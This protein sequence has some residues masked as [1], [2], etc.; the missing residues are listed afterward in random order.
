M[1]R[2]IR[3]K[4]G[5]LK[6]AEWGGVEGKKCNN[7]E[8][9]LRAVLA[10]P[11][12]TREWKPAPDSNTRRVIVQVDGTGPFIC[13]RLVEFE[14]G[15]KPEA[16]QKKSTGDETYK[17]IPV[18][19]EEAPQGYENEVLNDSLFF[20]ARGDSIRVMQSATIRSGA[21]EEHINWILGGKADGW[22]AGYLLLGNHLPDDIPGKIARIGVEELKVGVELGDLLDQEI[23]DD[24]GTFDIVEGLLGTL[25][26]KSTWATR[27]GRRLKEEK[28][29][30]LKTSVSISLL[31][32]GGERA[33]RLLNAL[34]LGLRDDAEGVT[35]T[36]QDGEI[37]RGNQL[38]KTGKF[39][40]EYFD[41][42]PAVT[43]VY[44][45]LKSIT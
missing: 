2:A 22:D 8:T 19:V 23:P 17:V 15:K 11:E 16:V 5:Y 41:G 18:D 43:Q 1:S 31:K 40:V 36:L 14:L 12:A 33:L 38:V 45:G 7:L 10:N 42:N 25:A 34:A 29:G 27:L 32:A 21:I 39:K 6:K 4:T 3:T 30:G 26:L 9:A 37:I 13:G 20:A 35:L 28:F 44:S 24:V